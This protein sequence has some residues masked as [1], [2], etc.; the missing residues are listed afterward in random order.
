M[1]ENSSALAAK[2]VVQFR[3]QS[4]HCRNKLNQTFGNQY[5]TEVI[6]LSSS[7]GYNL[8]DVS[9]HIVQR[10]VISLYFFR[11][12]AYVQLN[13][14]CTFQS[15]VRSRTTHQLNEVPVFAGRVT[16]A[17]DIS[18][19]LR[20]YFLAVSKPKEVSIISF[21]SHRQLF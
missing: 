6:A 10:H 5:G 7:V 16:V 18:N 19:H 17:L 9:Y 4:L 1:C 15:D 11:N 21:S 14:K 13:L 8:G 20:V 2:E 12:N 3:D